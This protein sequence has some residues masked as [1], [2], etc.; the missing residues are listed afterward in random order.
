MTF[1]T[2][3]TFT[4]SLRICSQYQQAKVYYMA[5]RVSCPLWVALDYLIAEEWDE[6]DALISLRGDI[7]KTL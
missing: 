6:E 1:N 5:D 7:K 3:S 4:D 2:K